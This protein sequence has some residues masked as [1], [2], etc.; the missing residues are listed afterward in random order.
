MYTYF[1]VPMCEVWRRRLH[2]TQGPRSLSFTL[3]QC[4]PSN[5]G[6]VLVSNAKF[7]NNNKFFS[8]KSALVLLL[9][10]NIIL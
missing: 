6:L 3:L 5:G 8:V 10:F 4:P 7:D 2:T 1:Q 9:T